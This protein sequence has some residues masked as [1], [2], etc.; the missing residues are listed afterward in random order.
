MTDA[1]SAFQ[2]S[3]AAELEPCRNLPGVLDVRV[4]GAIGVVQ[5]DREA[6][7]LRDRFAPLGVWVRPFRDIVYLTPP[8]IVSEDDLSILTAAIVQ[9]V[10]DW[11][12][13]L[14]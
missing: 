13:S 12:R 1:W 11:S 9:V 10:G 8:L 6:G 3:L 4:K 7:F 2:A 5:L 14:P